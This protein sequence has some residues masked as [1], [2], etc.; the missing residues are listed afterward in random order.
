VFNI[1]DIKHD[2][3]PSPYYKNETPEEFEKKHERVHKAVD[4]I[5]RKYNINYK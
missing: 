1:H 4:K 2:A 3:G 5:L